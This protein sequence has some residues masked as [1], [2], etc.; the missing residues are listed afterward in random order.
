MKSRLQSGLASEAAQ[1]LMATMVAMGLPQVIPGPNQD[2]GHTLDMIVGAVATCSGGGS[3]IPS[4]MV[5]PCPG[6]CE[7]LQCCLLLQED[8]TYLNGPPSVTRPT[9]V[10]EEAR[11]YPGGSAALPYGGF[12][13][14]PNQKAAKAL[15][16]IHHS[17]NSLWFLE[18]LKVLKGS[19]DA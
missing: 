7:N 18:E 2:S 8:K 14:N 4:G 12:G 9:L 5:R 6:G 19:Q 17:Q 1:E 15:N 10:P 11:G 3:V 13:Y 16:R